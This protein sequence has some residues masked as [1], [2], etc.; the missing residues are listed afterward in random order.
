MNE[1][2]PYNAT[3][4]YATARRNGLV[5]GLLLIGFFLVKNM[6]GLTDPGAGWASAINAAVVTLIFMFTSHRAIVSYRDEELDGV[7]SYGKAFG[8]AMLNITIG[9]ALLLVFSYVFMKFIDR[10]II[11]AARESAYQAL[12]NTDLNE[13]EFEKADSIMQSVTGPGILAL[14]SFFINL[15]WGAIVALGISAAI[16]S[17]NNKIND[18]EEL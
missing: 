2:N 15:L 9:L 10:S 13:E 14:S 7:I 16:P 1:N 11:D 4:P 6:A 8:V 3:T 12:E 17:N 5:C 18:K